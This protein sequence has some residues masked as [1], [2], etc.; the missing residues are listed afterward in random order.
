MDRLT[1]IFHNLVDRSPEILGIVLATMDGFP[2]IY[3][4]RGQ[5]DVD[6]QAAVIA[7][8]ASLAKRST[9]MVDIGQSEEI[10]ITSERGKMFV[11]LVGDTAVLG[12]ITAKEVTTGMILLKVRQIL[13]VISE[14]LKRELGGRI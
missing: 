12:I 7:S 11:Y 14:E 1:R 4:A 8:L 2:L 10:L 13:P 9:E 3:A 6:R 5:V